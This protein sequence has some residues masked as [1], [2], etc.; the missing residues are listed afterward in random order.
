MNVLG[1]VFPTQALLPAMME[2]REGKIVFVASQA[3]QVNRNKK[4]EPSCHPQSLCV[5][6]A[7]CKH[8]ILVY[9]KE[10]CFRLQFLSVSILL[11]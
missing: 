6:L 8:T 7:T 1:S 3:G 5:H 4:L 9:P 11:Q 10:S 2:R